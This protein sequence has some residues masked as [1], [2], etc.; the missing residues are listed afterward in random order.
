R[1]GVAAVPKRNACLYGVV[2]SAFPG[3]HHAELVIGVDI[4]IQP[5]VELV[6]LGWVERTP[7]GIVETTNAPRP[8]DACRIQAV[9]DGVI[10]R[11]WHPSQYYVLNKTGRIVSRPEGIAAEHAEGLKISGCAR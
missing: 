4:V 5:H 3:I 9:A 8:P 2:Q 11:R 6:P 7:V 10:V 1:A